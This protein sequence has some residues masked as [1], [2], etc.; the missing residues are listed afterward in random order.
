MKQLNYIYLQNNFK[1][2][3]NQNNQNKY[4][5]NLNNP[6]ILNIDKYFNLNKIMTYSTTHLLL[7]NLLT[8]GL[9]QKFFLLYCRSYRSFFSDIIYNKNDSFSKYYYHSEFK[10]NLQ[11]NYQLFNIESCILWYINILNSMFYLKCSK[12]PKK[13]RKQIKNVYT[14]K[15]NYIIPNKRLKYTLRFF[16]LTCFKNFNS[17][18]I[19]KM[20]YLG[21]CDYMLNF[22][23]S[24]SYLFKTKMYNQLLK[25]K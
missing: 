7:N 10:Y 6:Y 24:N 4:L 1:I 9:K 5:Y 12:V 13:Y 25:T 11:F 16:Y 22:K 17:N 18:N 21:I 8:K 20:L 2:N 3:K 15:F 23:K 14:Y 19:N